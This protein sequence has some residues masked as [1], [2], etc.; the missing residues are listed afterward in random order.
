MTK[1]QAIIL[2]FI[3]IIIGGGVTLYVTSS[4]D[5][6]LDVETKQSESTP[7]TSASETPVVS[8][9]RTITESVS[10]NVPEDGLEHITVECV[11]D[12]LGNIVDVKFSYAT[13]SHR[14]SREMLGSFSKNFKPSSLIG[15]KIGDTKLSRVGG[16]SL[17]TN[18]F[19]TAMAAIKTKVNG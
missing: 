1:Q 7:T 12:S 17:T 16:A 15:T 5:A 6:V 9:N 3:L 2:L 10:Y 18:A 19:N 13:P 4:K 11:V 8:T 14:E